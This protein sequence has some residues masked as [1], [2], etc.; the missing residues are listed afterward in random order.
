MIDLDSLRRAAAGG[1][2]QP[3][4]VTRDW[5]AQVAREIA[6]AR[7]GSGRIEKRTAA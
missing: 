6:E 2:K 4:C 3:V 1:G 5:L 7:R